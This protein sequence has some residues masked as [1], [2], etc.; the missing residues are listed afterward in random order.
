MNVTELFSAF[1][2]DIKDTVKPYLVS[3]DSAF[4]YLNEAQT[5][6]TRRAHLLVSSTGPASTASVSAGES[7]VDIDQ[8]IIAI[9]RIRL[10]S[11]SNQLRMSRVREMDSFNPGWDA[12]SSQSTPSF[13]ILDYETDK[14]Y[15]YPTPAV[16]DDLQMTV[17]REPVKV[18]NSEDDAPEI[19]PRWHLSLIEWMKFRTYINED[20]ELFDAKAADR[21]LALFEQEF[22]PK[23]SASD[24]AF[25]YAE[26]HD[27]GEL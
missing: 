4:L 10:A 23:R 18:L 7:I 11:Q 2:R 21:A 16:A 13:A 14:I 19:A 26:Y 9:R 12:S 1:R 24:E 3:D 20:S 22:G 6:A 25:E 17:V 8:R 15:L 5:E 27:I